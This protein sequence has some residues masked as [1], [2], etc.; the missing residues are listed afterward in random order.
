MHSEISL[1]HHSV[2]L[3]LERKKFGYEGEE[4]GRVAARFTS[5]ERAELTVERRECFSSGVDL[6]EHRWVL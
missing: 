6:F 4:G 1:H 2:Y 3:H 5:R